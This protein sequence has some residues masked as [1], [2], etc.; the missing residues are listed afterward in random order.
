MAS[1]LIIRCTTHHLE[2]AS[3]ILH[4]KSGSEAHGRLHLTDTS[5]RVTPVTPSV[6]FFSDDCLPGSAVT[7]PEVVMVEGANGEGTDGARAAEGTNEE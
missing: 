6:A 1:P 2:D 3:G 7:R 5:P 4:F